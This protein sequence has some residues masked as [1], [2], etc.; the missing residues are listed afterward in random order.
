ML[1]QVETSVEDPII[2]DSTAVTRAE[3]RF[4]AQAFCV[5]VLTCRGKAL[6]VVQQVPRGFRFKAWRQLFERVRATSSS[7]VPRNVPSPL[8]ANDVR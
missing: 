1:Q 8:V 5:L 3:K 7:K 6:Q 4:S 2:T